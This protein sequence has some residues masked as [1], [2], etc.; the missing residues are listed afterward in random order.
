MS[1]YRNQDT[2]LRLMEVSQDCTSEAYKNT[3]TT[4]TYYSN[5]YCGPVQH[6]DDWDNA[7]DTQI[8]GDEFIDI[9]EIID[10]D[11]DAEILDLD[12]Y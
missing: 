2:E 3:N 1:K 9:E 11:T 7:W 6:A 8:D 4:N 12:D 5:R 10:A